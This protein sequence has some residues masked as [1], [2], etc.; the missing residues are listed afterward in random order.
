[1]LALDWDSLGWRDRQNERH[2]LQDNHLHVLFGGYGQL[3]DPYSHTPVLYDD[4]LLQQG[5]IQPCPILMYH[6]MAQCLMKF[7]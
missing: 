5:I 6:K 3:L 7:H 2:Q 4:P 1:M